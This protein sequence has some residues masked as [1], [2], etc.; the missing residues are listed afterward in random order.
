V[1]IEHPSDGGLDE[2]V[3]RFRADN[4][5]DEC[6]RVERKFCVRREDRRSAQAELH[7]TVVSFP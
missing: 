3:I 2:S 4:D 5:L 6:V 1:P 7:F